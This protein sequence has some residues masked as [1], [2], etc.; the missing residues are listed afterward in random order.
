MHGFSKT[1]GR[2]VEGYCFFNSKE[3]IPFLN[4]FWS[5]DNCWTE[6]DPFEEL[7][8]LNS[9]RLWVF[10]MRSVLSFNLTIFKLFY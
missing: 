4:F 10:G 6:F 8:I 3:S 9:L 7:F 5:T 1:M 2:L